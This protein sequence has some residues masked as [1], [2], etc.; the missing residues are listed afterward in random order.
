M[1]CSKLTNRRSLLLVGLLCT[2]L[3]CRPETLLIYEI[4]TPEKVEEWTITPM[5]R[6]EAVHAISRSTPRGKSA[7]DLEFRVFIG[8]KETLEEAAMRMGAKRENGAMQ[9]QPLRISVFKDR[10]PGVEDVR[11]LDFSRFVIRRNNT[12]IEQIAFENFQKCCAHPALIDYRWFFGAKYQGQLELELPDYMREMEED[13]ASPEEKEQAQKKKITE[14]KP[15]APSRI[16]SGDRLAA[17]L[18]F[19]PLEIETDYILSHRDPGVMPDLPFRIT[20]VRR[21]R[22]ILD[23]WTPEASERAISAEERE[24]LQHEQEDTFIMHRQLQKHA[25]LRDK[26]QKK[27]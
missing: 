5:R 17:W 1:P 9:V 2:L 13:T 15:W 14:W 19:P 21:N 26:E 3:H 24:I 8:K 27:N 12:V 10:L 20:M 23:T 18:I 22:E 25:E 6:G 7:S 11:I 4:K 16:R